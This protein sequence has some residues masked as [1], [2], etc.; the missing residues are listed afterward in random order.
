MGLSIELLKSMNGQHAVNAL[1]ADFNPLVNTELESFLIDW[2]ESLVDEA[3]SEL[4]TEAESYGINGADIKTL[5]EALIEDAATSAALLSA[6]GE[7]GI[8][9][10]GT[11]KEKL[12]RAD[13]FYDIATDAGDV[14]SRLNTLVAET[15]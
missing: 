1:R 4:R 11:L 8:D 7:A 2:I 3:D 13:Q 12:K 9:S 10:P 5:G 6:L 14:F 15:L